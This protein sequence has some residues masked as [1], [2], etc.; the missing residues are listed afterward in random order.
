MCLTTE[1]HSTVFIYEMGIVVVQSLSH[2]PLS[3]TPWTA[4]R[5]V[6]LSF[7][8]S[9]SL[10]KLMSIESVVPPNHLIL[11]CPLLLQPSIFLSIRVFSNESALCIRW[12]EYWRFSIS[13]SP[14]KEHLGLISFRISLQSK[15]LSRV[16]SNTAVQKH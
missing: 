3:V 13:I 11:C 2:V 8:I 14:S 1:I 6:S 4:A 15:V 9:W 5:Q 7:T 12:P 10:L 16:F